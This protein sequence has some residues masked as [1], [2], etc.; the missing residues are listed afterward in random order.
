MT[1]AT[2]LDVGLKTSGSSVSTRTSL[3]TTH[4][5]KKKKYLLLL[6][7]NKP[8]CPFPLRLFCVFKTVVSLAFPHWLGYISLP[9]GLFPSPCKVILPF[10]PSGNL[11]TGESS[12]SDLLTDSS[13]VFCPP[14]HSNCSPKGHQWHSI[15]KC[16]DLFSIF[17]LPDLSELIPRAISSLPFWKIHLCFLIHSLLLVVV[18]VLLPCFPF[19]PRLP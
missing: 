6:L 17:M 11:Q 5:L 3:Y 7:K 14:R 4:C 12:P 19:F 18:F 15:S 9:P 1:L 2:R 13:S 10:H 16:G 8:A